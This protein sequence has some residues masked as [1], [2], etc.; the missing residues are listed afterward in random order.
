MSSNRH[1]GLFTLRATA[2]GQEE[3]LSVITDNTEGNVI[4]VRYM[5]GDNEPHCTLVYL[6]TQDIITHSYTHKKYQC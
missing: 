4:F 5:S 1:M 6:H 3:E 2:P